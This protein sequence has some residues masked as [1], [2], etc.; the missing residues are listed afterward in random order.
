[1]RIY[2]NI[3]VKVAGHSQRIRQK[4]KFHWRC[5]VESEFIEIP[6]VNWNISGAAT[7][8]NVKAGTDPEGN[9]LG[10]VAWIDFFGDMTIDSSGVAH[11]TLK[12]PV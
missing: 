3:W 12:D 2:R 7:P 6:L 1:M 8:R 10:L 11:I 5:Y 4:D 9:A